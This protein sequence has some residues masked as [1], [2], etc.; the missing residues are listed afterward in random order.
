MLKNKS[1]KASHF[2]DRE[3]EAHRKIVTS[4]RSPTQAVAVLWLKS[5]RC[6]GC[7]WW[8]GQAEGL[9]GSWEEKY[10]PR[11]QIVGEEA[12]KAPQDL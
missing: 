10:E 7:H 6:V 5:D 11:G 12:A 2:T 8:P 3:N 4:L 1:L 9:L